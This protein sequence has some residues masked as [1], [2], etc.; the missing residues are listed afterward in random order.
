MKGSKTIWVGIFIAGGILLFGLG[1]FIIGSSQQMFQG[2]FH[3]YTDFKSID[4]LTKGA[5]VRVSGA[6]A[7][8]VTDIDVPGTPSSQFRLHLEIDEKFHHVVRQNSVTTIETA[9]MVGEKYVDI[10]IG[11]ENSPECNQCMLPSQA[12]VDM[13]ALMKQG[14]GLVKQVQGTIQDVQHH[15][16]SAIDNFSSIATNVNHVIDHEQNKIDTIANNTAHLTGSANAIAVDIQQGRGTAGKLLTDEAMASN[17]ESTIANAKQTS[18]N[19][20]QSSKSVQSMISN[21]QQQDIPDV[22][23]TLQ[24]AKDMSNQLDQAV[25]T[26]LATSNK[27]ENTA[28]ALR[29]AVQ[30]TS[31]ATGNLADDT[32]AI[33]HNFFLRGF[34][35]RRGYFNLG[36]ITRTEYVGTPFV[37]KPTV[38]VWLPDTGLF[39]IAPDGT[40]QL[41][42]QGK[43]LL[44]EN[45]SDLVPYLPRN[46]IMVE[47]YAELGQPDQ[48]YIASRERAIAVR[49][50][51]ESRFHLN[52][53]IVGIMPMGNHPPEQTGKPQW[54]GVALVLVKSR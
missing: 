29:A 37:K 7:G 43:Q 51:L 32:E 2:H 13:G 27:N 52:S 17:V 38:R 31:E 16:D 24:N 6:D 42:D 14:A 1:L 23:A 26:F 22:H 50:Y 12:P 18:A 9:G 28:E 30:N 15:A 11:S 36:E 49:A 35:K 44:D 54:S 8:Q 41:T 21:V 33:K 46:P 4:T 19:L 5:K 20:E 45:M 25:G 10:A 53:K 48:R 47:G 40:Q 39:I 3:A 34:F